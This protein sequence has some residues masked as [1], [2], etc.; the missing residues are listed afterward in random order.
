LQID[1]AAFFQFIPKIKNLNFQSFFKGQEGHKV[2]VVHHVGFGGALY[3]LPS[4]ACVA[5]I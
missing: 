1:A 4:P 5:M 3:R 2:G